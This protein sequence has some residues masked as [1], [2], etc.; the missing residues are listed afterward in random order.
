MSDFDIKEKFKKISIRGRFAF[1]MKCIE[2]Y[3]KENV[4]KDRWISKLINALWE[5]TTSN[6]LDVWDEKIRDLDPSNILDSHPNNKASDYETL[7]ENDF[8]ELK[9]CY[10]NLNIDFINLIGYVLEI[11]TRNLYGGTGTYSKFTLEPTMQVYELSTKILDE[12]P[13]IENF[14][15]F[16]YKEEHGWGKIINKKE[17]NL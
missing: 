7:T 11:G 17:L 9:I 13:K 1:G 3:K 15:K 5:F 6:E 16:T 12:I 14:I 8:K 10:Q 2:Q 4:I